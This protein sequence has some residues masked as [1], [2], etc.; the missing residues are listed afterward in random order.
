MGRRCSHN[1]QHFLGAKRRRGV[2]GSVLL[3]AVHLYDPGCWGKAAESEEGIM[4]HITETT[5]KVNFY[6]RINSLYNKC[7]AG[8]A[9]KAFDAY[10]TAFPVIRK[11]MEDFLDREVILDYISSRFS[12][13]QES[14]TR[15]ARHVAKIQRESE[16][17]LRDGISEEVFQEEKR[18]E[19]RRVSRKAEVM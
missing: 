17:A 16:E 19:S 7:A 11:R 4:K 10:V 18:K 5:H 15:S 9:V 2:T 12:E 6:L 1:Q 14:R 13:Y 3:D 8:A